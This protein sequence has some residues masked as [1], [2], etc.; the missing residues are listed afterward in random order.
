MSK[1]SVLRSRWVRIPL[2]TAA[3]LVLGAASYVGSRLGTSHPA[4][5][6]ATA[7]VDAE[8]CDADE[9]AEMLVYTSLR[10][11]NLDVYL[12]DALD[13]EPR[14]LT[15][16]PN[17]DYK[18]VLSRDGRWVVFVSDRDGATNLYALDLHAGAEPIAL[19]TH[20][21]MDDAPTL[22]PDGARIALDSTRGGRPDIWSMHFAPG[23]PA[24]ETRAVNLTDHPYGDFNPAF[25]PDGSRIAFSSNRALFRRWN[26]L[27]LV[28]D[29][30][31]VT[32]IYVMN[33]D[34]S[35]PRRVVRRLGVAGSP[36]WTEDGSALLYYLQTGLG[37]S[38][39]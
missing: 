9:H 21:G 17:L 36:A 29:A 4:K 32:D 34:G 24:A 22:S 31:S 15:D 16:H 18:P 37:S 39:V 2:L 10:P 7:V 30:E 11:A 6:D 26:P 1:P 20:A 35:G 12:F 5:Y 19:T 13:A 23:D 14:R 25:S 33:A 27:R 38:A 3:L 28:P 8:P